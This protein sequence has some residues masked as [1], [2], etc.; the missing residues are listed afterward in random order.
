[1]AC[2][3]SGRWVLGS[4]ALSHGRLME[5]ARAVIG[6][7]EPA[8]IVNPVGNTD[9]P[10]PGLRR[11]RT[12]RK[13]SAMLTQS[14]RLPPLRICLLLG[15]PRRVAPTTEPRLAALLRPAPTSGRTA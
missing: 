10:T 14:T 7:G 6:S 4:I 15:G 9:F 12:F 13:E 5:P 3:W 8:A 2:G 1:M 11:S